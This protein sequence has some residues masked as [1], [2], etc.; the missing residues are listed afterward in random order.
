M[1]L[2]DL[3]WVLVGVALGMDA[4][5]WLALGVVLGGGLMWGLLR[6]RRRRP[7]A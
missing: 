4:P 7:G 6:I 5:L 1:S 2:M 3:V